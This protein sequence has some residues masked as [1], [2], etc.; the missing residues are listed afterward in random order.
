MGE[1]KN[2]LTEDPSGPSPYVELKTTTS[3]ARIYLFGAHV[4]S[5]TCYG[6]EMLWMSSLSNFDGSA[7]IRGGVPIA[8][9]QFADQG[10]LK[11]HG[12]VRDSVWTLRES[13]ETSATLT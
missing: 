12:F 8:W 9:P 2:M 7:P 3:T 11:L 10:P 4:T 1:F 5:W 6:R 13:S